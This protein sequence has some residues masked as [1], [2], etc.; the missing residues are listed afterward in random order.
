MASS[1][2]W[3]RTKKLTIVTRFITGDGTDNGNL[4]EIK[5]YYIQDGKVYPNA[6]SVIPGLSPAPEYNSIENN[7]CD[8]QKAVFG[9]MNHFQAQGGLQGVGESLKRGVVLSFSILDDWERHLQWLDGKWPVDW[10]PAAPGVARGPCDA[11]SGDPE[12]TRLNTPNSG[13]RISNIKFGP[14]GTTTNGQI[15]A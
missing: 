6:I 2:S 4:V 7:Y 12:Y 15:P 14:I 1:R 9:E 8:N 11:S 13:V 3:T 5:R 10:D